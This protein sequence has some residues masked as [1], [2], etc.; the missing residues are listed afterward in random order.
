[1]LTVISRSS[2][3]RD[4]V[5]AVQRLS[6]DMSAVIGLLVDHVNAVDAQGTRAP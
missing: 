5:D 6:V 1:M 3:R 4:V 2:L